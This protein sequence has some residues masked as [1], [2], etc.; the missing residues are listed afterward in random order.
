MS[1]DDLSNDILLN[2]FIYLDKSSYMQI[3][4]ANKRINGLIK[5]IINKRCQLCLIRPQIINDFCVCNNHRITVYY[6]DCQNI[7][8]LRAN[9]EIT[10]NFLHGL[11]GIVNYDMT[12]L[13]DI[14]GTY[15]LTFLFGDN[16]EDKIV[17]VKN[18]NT[19]IPNACIASFITINKITA[20]CMLMKDN[21]EKDIGY[22]LNVH[23]SEAY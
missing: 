2:I 18:N 11:H 23:I 20:K 9:K 22:T 14:T 13:S 15:K 3:L 17:Y 10:F 4:P 8:L 21:I 12:I 16:R 6:Y 1:L 5:Y 7:K 19:F